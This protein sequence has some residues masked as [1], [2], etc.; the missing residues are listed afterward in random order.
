MRAARGI[1]KNSGPPWRRISIMLLA[2]A[3]S[4]IVAGFLDL[5]TEIEITAWN[6][7]ID[8][9]VGDSTLSTRVDIGE[10][11]S[12]GVSAQA[13]IHPTGGSILEARTP[14]GLGRRWRMPGRFSF[15]HR[16]IPPVGDWWVDEAT[17]VASVFSA[18]APLGSEFTIRGIITGRHHQHLMITLGGA[19][20]VTCSFRRGLLNN[21]LL[22]Q[23]DRGEA[24]AWGALDPQPLDRL[25]AAAS[26][27]LRA[28]TGG[29]LLLALW[30][31]IP[32]SGRKTN[33][34]APSLPTTVFVPVLALV[35]LGG[36]GLAAWTAVDI[37]D[38]LPHLPDEIV[39]QLQGRWLLSGHLT[40]IEPPCSEN[41]VV[42]LT[43]MRAGRWIGHYP[44]AWPLLLAPGISIGAPWLAPALLRI[45][46]ILIIGFLALRLGGRW[47]ALAAA[48]AALTSP[49]ALLLFGSRMPHAGSA[50]LLLFALLLCLPRTRKTAAGRW[51]LAGIAFGLAFG[52]RPLTAVAVA[53]PVGVFL[54]GETL[55][56]RRRWQDGLWLI[57][58][59][60][61]ASLPTFLANATITGSPWAFPYSLA[62]GSMYSIRHAAFGIRNL[63]ALLASLGPLVHGW[64]W[65]WLNGPISLALPFAFVAVLF[66]SRQSNREDRL[67]A[68]VAMTVVLAHFGTRAT[69]L[70][71]FGPRY[72]FIPC[73]ITWILTA[74]GA[75]VLASREKNRWPVSALVLA[76]LTIGSAAVTPARLSLYRGYNDVTTT[77]SEAA[78]TL[79][80]CSLVLFP[81]ENWRGWAEAS[82]RLGLD[83]SHIDP[84]PLFAADLGETLGLEWCFPDR[85]I[86]RWIDGRMIPAIDESDRIP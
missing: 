53:I 7:R 36:A 82:P 16:H 38:N 5:K 25:A 85:H 75:A 55:A 34:I 80:N 6:G 12:I 15:P 20:G 13:G 17:D 18:S 64:G 8:W 35:A 9:T 41:F 51:L 32:G 59:G 45:P 79:P 10:I 56:Q 43:Y 68:A 60:L 23:D 74:R 46:H 24:L 48:A 47:T 62:E 70:H 29:A 30:S 33:P 31:V 69:G 27:V 65:P 40:G 58:G 22:I 19:Q 72:F 11:D 28:V 50:T 77:M 1:V 78:S 14:G 81:E 57:F 54:T 67:L 37:F 3:A 26:T 4:W 73:C 49:L 42:P 71:G 2:A 86:F 39:Y 83:P 61:S 52:M 84:G 66:L 21:D 63:D 44:P 76:L